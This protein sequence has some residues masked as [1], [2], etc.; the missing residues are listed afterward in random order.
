MRKIVQIGNNTLREISHDVP[1]DEIKSTKIQ[2][3]ISDMKNALASQ[4]D[5]VA[6]AAP[7]IG[8]NLRIFVVSN[9]VFETADAKDEV[10]INPKIIKRSRKKNKV[11]EGCL[12]V[13]GTFGNIVRHEKIT[14]EARNENGDKITR[15]GSNLLAQIFQH[16]TDHLD[17]VL[18]VD[19][20]T[21]LIDVE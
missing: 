8:V 21:D 20:A 14:I 3:I 10:Y 12:S 18:F 15:G 1:V 19:N 7:Q 11:E 4:D 2:K 17:G 5:G 9:K 13:R 16:E 6:I